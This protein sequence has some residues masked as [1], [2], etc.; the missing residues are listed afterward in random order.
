MSGAAVE[1]VHVAEGVASRATYSTCETYRYAL[2]RSWDPDGPRIAYVMLNPS[3]AS[4]LANDPTVERCERRAR[5]MGYGAFRV[6]NLFAFRA[7]APADLRRA[8]APE[9][10][11]NPGAIAA[12]CDWA[13]MV[14]AAWGVHGAHRGAGPA[15]AADLAA[16]G[17]AMHHLGLTRDGHPRHPLFVAYST[18]P[19][20]WEF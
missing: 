1:R 5:A 13:D 15:L 17:Q 2:E 19:A 3:T 10:P 8:E 14:L 9:G 18:L 16:R 4:E 11:G 20:P 6:V 12:A 7:T